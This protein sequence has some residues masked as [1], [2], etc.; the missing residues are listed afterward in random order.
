MSLVY[1]CDSCDSSISQDDV[2]SGDALEFQGQHYCVDCKG[3]VLAFMKKSQ[4]P[5]AE[6]AD[7]APSAP[8]ASRDSPASRPISS[9]SSR[10][11][12]GVEHESGRSVK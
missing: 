9:R 8:A 3:P 2:L 11:R 4:V 7:E 12:T 1:R 5:P 6:L 10:T